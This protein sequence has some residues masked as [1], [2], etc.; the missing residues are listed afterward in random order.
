MSLYPP[1]LIKY[2]LIPHTELGRG[3]HDYMWL[4]MVLI[5]VYCMVV[6][7][8]NITSDGIMLTE[9]WLL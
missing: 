5:V 6:E 1:S 2:K 4:R 8:P 3:K 7:Y 9:H